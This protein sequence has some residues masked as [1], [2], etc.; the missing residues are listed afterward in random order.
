MMASKNPVLIALSI[1][2]GFSFICMGL[3]KVSQVIDKE[4]HRDVRKT[5]K[6]F[7]KVFPILP[8]LGVYV[9][10]KYYRL[11]VGYT[12]LVGG[13]ILLLLL[14][15]RRIQLLANGSLLIVSLL[16]VY[17]HYVLKD[18]FER[19]APYLVFALMLSCRM[20][21][22]YQVLKR[23]RIQGEKLAKTQTYDDNQQQQIAE[24]NNDEEQIDESKKRK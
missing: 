3:L 11:T 4:L 22:F 7:A 6:N 2:L 21:V 15:F 19:I 1:L 16:T 23:D 24:N 9:S 17:S 10:A 13:L 12:E 14:P 5:F 18:K 20:V 8:N